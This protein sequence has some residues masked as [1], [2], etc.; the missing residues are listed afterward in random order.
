MKIKITQ[1]FQ[2]CL[3]LFFLMFFLGRC[4]HSV[5]YPWNCEEAEEALA[6]AEKKLDKAFEQA[7]QKSEGH[8]VNESFEDIERRIKLA[9]FTKI[10]AE[11]DKY[12]KCS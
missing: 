4:V 11:K 12:K 7:K 10:Y 1:L 8:I 9:V 5:G 2:I 3:V 6:E